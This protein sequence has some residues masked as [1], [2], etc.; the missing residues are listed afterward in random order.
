ML[1]RHLLVA[2]RHTPA[3]P[4]RPT[5]AASPHPVRQGR[6]TCAHF[7]SRR[8]P[9]PVGGCTAHKT[10]SGPMHRACSCTDTTCTCARAAPARSWRKRR[11]RRR[12]RLPA[13]L[14]SAQPR[15]PAHEH[16]YRR[17]RQW[18]RHA[19]GTGAPPSAAARHRACACTH[20]DVICHNRRH[21]HAPVRR[22]H[23]HAHGRR[24]LP[25][26]TIQVFMCWQ[27]KVAPDGSEPEPLPPR[28]RRFRHRAVQVAA[29]G[30]GAGSYR[31]CSCRRPVHW[32]GAVCA[33]CSRRRRRRASR[34]EVR[35][36]RSPLLLDEAE[37]AAVGLV[38]RAGGARG[39]EQVPPAARLRSTARLC[40]TYEQHRMPMSPAAPSRRCAGLAR[41]DIALQARQQSAS[42]VHLPVVFE[43]PL[44]QRRTPVLSGRQGAPLQHS[45]EKRALLA[46]G[47]AA[48]RLA[49]VAFGQVVVEPP[50]Q[51]GTPALSSLQQLYLGRHAVAANLAR[52]RAARLRRLVPQDVAFRIADAPPDGIEQKPTGGLTPETITQVTRP[53]PGRF[54]RWRRSSPSPCSRCRPG[55]GSAGEL[56]HRRLRR[57]RCADA[58][59]AGCAARQ[60]SPSIEQLPVVA[61]AM[62]VPRSCPTGSSSCRCS[63]RCGVTDVAERLAAGG[64]GDAGAALAV[65]EQQFGA[66][67][68]ALPS[69]VQPPATTRAHMRRRSLP[70]QHCASPV[71]AVP[72]CVQAAGAAAADAREAAA[73]HRTWC[74]R[75]PWRGSF[76]AAACAAGAADEH[77]SSSTSRAAA[78]AAVAVDAA[79]VAGCSARRRRRSCGCV[80]LV[81]E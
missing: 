66:V 72:F 25:Q 45:D 53:W 79:G 73:L 13:R 81:D 59:A 46:G 76:T 21:P 41:R 34:V 58:A 1:R 35:A 23:L 70:L 22:L 50:K 78:D 18:C 12:Q 3:R 80:A 10:G 16:L 67:V 4:T 39:D 49:V 30:A 38:G 33:P 48:A 24:H 65:C 64:G 17:L 42:L 6:S 75:R 43:Q 74:R 2:G 31:E 77:V 52:V 56:T 61:I 47:D 5:A 36:C 8:S 11:R 62:Q 19:C 54:D 28:R 7:Y 37:A 63:T 32:P 44:P 20:V 9:S 26:S 60:T 55:C 71:Q 15:L 68:Q 29:L 40:P 14:P 27:S 51:R 57:R 69:V